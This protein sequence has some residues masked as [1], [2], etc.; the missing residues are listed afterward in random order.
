MR[1]TYSTRPAAGLAGAGAGAGSLLVDEVGKGK[2]LRFG[3]V[4]G[5]RK[6]ASAHQLIDDAVDGGEELL[7]IL[8][9][10]GFR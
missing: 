1:R 2:E 6:I 4:N 5:D 3:V 10:A 9:G 8:G 7:E